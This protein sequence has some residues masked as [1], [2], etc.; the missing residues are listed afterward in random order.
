[1]IRNTSRRLRSGLIGDYIN[2]LNNQDIEYI[3]RY[4]IDNL[5]DESK[6]IYFPDLRNNFK[7]NYHSF[8]IL[9][10]SEKDC[11][12]LINSLKKNN[13]YAYIGYV[14]LHTSK[15]GYEYNFHKFKLKNTEKYSKRILR[16]PFHNF[17]NKDDINKVCS[18]IKRS[19]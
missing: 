19:I 5:T 13:I 15:I 16:L 11:T 10:K 3:R 9:L 12:L 17:L 2:H 6:K 14:P 1:M 18:L 7:S 4:C 8:W